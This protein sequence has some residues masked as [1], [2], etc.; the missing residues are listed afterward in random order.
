MIE[1]DLKY[2]IQMVKVILIIDV[3]FVVVNLPC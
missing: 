3:T 2:A 1:T